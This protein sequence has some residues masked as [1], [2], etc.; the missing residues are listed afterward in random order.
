MDQH[1][2]TKLNQ[3]VNY[4]CLPGHNGQCDRAAVAVL[5]NETQARN[6]E[7]GEVCAVFL[8]FAFCYISLERGIHSGN[9]PGEDLCG[10]WGLKTKE[11]PG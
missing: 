3:A 2:F 7:N 4:L 11:P 6:E 9:P 1:L 5:G 10:P 8:A